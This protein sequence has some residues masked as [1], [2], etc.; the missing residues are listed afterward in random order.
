MAQN[1][2][3]LIF[4]GG[5]PKQPFRHG[6]IGG[7]FGPLHV[8]HKI[9][10][11]AALIVCDMVI[12][13]VTNDETAQEKDKDIPDFDSRFWAVKQYMDSIT[14][15]RHYQIVPIDSP[16]GMAVTTEQAEIIICSD[17]EEVI[18]EVRRINMERRAMNLHEI[19]VLM[20][21]RVRGPKGLAISSTRIRKGELPLEEQSGIAEQSS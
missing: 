2:F 17:E 16:Y 10:F 4:G 12:I 11:K 9:L 18:E 6:I 1:P 13:G 8:G 20:V 21:P 14:D 5:G 15:F 7:T 19:L 3:E